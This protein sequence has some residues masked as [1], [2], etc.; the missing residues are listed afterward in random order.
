[1]NC[2]QAA[3]VY[4]S[5]MAPAK[6]RGAFNASFQ[7]FLSIGVVAANCINYATS[8]HSWGWRLSLGLAIVPASIIILGAFLITDTPIS[9][10]QRGKLDQAKIALRKVRGPTADVESELD[11]L[12][13]WTQKSKALKQEPFGSIVFER[14][15]RPY[16]VMALAIPFFQQL[17]GI[18]IVAFYSPHLFQSVGLGND[19][20]LLS[21]IILGLVNLASISLSGAVVDR[22][23]RR[24]LFIVGGIQMILC[25]VFITNY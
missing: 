19:A 6:W 25:Q 2:E 17:T 7:F 15:Y 5:E 12:I 22:F 20:A 13:K 24:F 21:T 14:Q 18:N 8:N 16:L 23:G 1:M 9:L 3:P 10:L 4:L 11:D